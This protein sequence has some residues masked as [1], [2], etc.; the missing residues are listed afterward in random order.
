[1]RSFGYIASRCTARYWA[2][3]ARSWLSSSG[4][5]PS[6]VHCAAMSRASGKVGTHAPAPMN[7]VHRALSIRSTSVNH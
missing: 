3:R 2:T 7:G 6:P 5:L 1:M 4:Y